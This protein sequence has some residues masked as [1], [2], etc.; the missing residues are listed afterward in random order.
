M[1]RKSPYTVELS[2]SQRAALEARA[3]KYSLPYNQVVRARMVLMAA[4]GLNN[5][6]IASRLDTRREI[7]SKWRKRFVLQG[8]SGLDERSRTGRPPDAIG[9]LAQASL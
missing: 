8:L 5:G 9:R 6:E 4:A 3:C 7:V 2:E 1:S